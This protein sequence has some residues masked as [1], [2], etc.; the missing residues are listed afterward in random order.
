MTRRGGSAITSEFRSRPCSHPNSRRLTRLGLQWLQGLARTN[1]RQRRAGGGSQNRVQDVLAGAVLL[2]CVHHLSVCIAAMPA[3]A[4]CSS[5]SVQGVSQ[6][7][8]D[9]STST[10]STSLECHCILLYMAC[11]DRWWSAPRR[12][13]KRSIFCLSVVTAISLLTAVPLTC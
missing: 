12:C 8:N 10:L 9:T 7:M 4:I 3:S 11:H 1:M 2:L 13:A 5:L 6:S